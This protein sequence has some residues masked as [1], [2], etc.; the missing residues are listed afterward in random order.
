M[1]AEFTTVIKLTK[2]NRLDTTDPDAF[3]FDKFLDRLRD[4][5]NTKEDHEILRKKCS[6]HAMGA[7]AWKNEGFNDDDVTHACFTN[8]QVNNHNNEMIQKIG[9]PIALI[10]ATNEGRASSFSDNDLG[11]LSSRSC[12]CVGALIFLTKNFLN[13]G[14]CNGSQGIVK[15]INYT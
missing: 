5:E 14:L 13:L 1:H 11:G 10:E 2:N 12:L 4:G 15:E 7:E 3:T 9:N 8:K 6:V